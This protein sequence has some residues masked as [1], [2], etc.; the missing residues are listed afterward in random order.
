MRSVDV[1][2]RR[3]RLGVRHSLASSATDAL[4]ATSSMVCLHSSD[5]T[6]VFLSL[7]ARVASIDTKEIEEEIYEKR[8]LVRI[9]GMRRTL[10]L[11]PR[12]DVAL[13]ANSSTRTIASRERKRTI[14]LLEDTGF[15]EDGAAWLDEVS[16]LVLAAIDESGAVLTRHLSSSIP[17]LE[18]KLTMYNKSGQVMGTT[19]VASRAI[20]QLSFESRLVR[21]QP[22]GSWISGQYRWATMQN[23][24]GHEIEEIPVATASAG[25]VAKLLLAFGPVTESDVKWWTGW[26]VTQVRRALEA[27]GAVEV[28]VDGQ[29][30]Y[31][32]ADDLDPVANPNSWVALLPSL[33]P[34][35]MGW[36]ERDWYLGSYGPRLF[37]RNGNA[38]P[39]VWVDGRIV[40]G[41]AQRPDGEVVYELFEEVGADASA[42]IED[43]VAA[44]STWLGDTTITPRF[45]SPHDR[46]LSS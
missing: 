42:A 43:R 22:A 20:L 33:D 11:V 24:L 21:A 10:W 17:E 23:W 40:G 31:L 14:K 28:G 29:V 41:W 34:T 35:A 8:T 15:A 12:D 38:G 16:P 4:G 6:T 1:A 45:R 2:E 26:P 27:V 18:G 3:A 46:S 25:I 9:Y 32:L 30:G 13:V 5:P 36:K 19:G 7:W 39:T 37:D 44:L